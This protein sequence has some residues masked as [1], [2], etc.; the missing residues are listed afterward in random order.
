M[1]TRAGA[2]VHPLCAY[3]PP[4]G[5]TTGPETLAEPLWMCAAFGLSTPR[6]VNAQHTFVPSMVTLALPELDVEIDAGTSAELDSATLK[7]APFPVGVLEELSSRVS[8]TTISTTAST[9][10]AAASPPAISLPLDPPPPDG[11]FAAGGGAAGGGGTTGETSVGGWTRPL[12]AARPPRRRPLRLRASTVSEG[13]GALVGLGLRRGEDGSGG[14]PARVGPFANSTLGRGYE[15]AAARVAV[16]LR[17]RHRLRD[18]TIERHGEIRPLIPHLR[19]R[20]Q[21]VGL[22]DGDLGVPRVRGLSGQARVEHAPERVDV[23][24]GVHV[25]ALD[26]LG[27]GEVRSADEEPSSRQPARGGGLGHAEIGQ[28]DAIRVPDQEDVRG[29][30]VPVH[31][32]VLVRGVERARHLVE[33]VQGPSDAERTVA[34]EDLARGRGPRRSAWRCRGTRSPLPRRRSG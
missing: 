10:A 13:S 14:H 33:D 28:V 22:E 9:T 31:E 15:V 6:S 7:V 19:R 16:V 29:L 1:V 24:A 20:L 21:Q 5:T 3:W 25:P 4:S 8:R 17:L 34:L 26:L 2:V 11:S 12:W 30:H 18:H 32:P 23:R 27:R